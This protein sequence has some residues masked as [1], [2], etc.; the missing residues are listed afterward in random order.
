MK[1]E[2]INE[3]CFH[4]TFFFFLHNIELKIDKTSKIKKNNNR[5]VIQRLIINILIYLLYY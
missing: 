2:K 1:R 5:K 3:K 4:F